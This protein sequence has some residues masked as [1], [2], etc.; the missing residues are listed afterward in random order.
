MAVDTVRCVAENAAV[1]IEVLDKNLVLLGD[2]APKL[3]EKMVGN[4]GWGVDRS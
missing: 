2:D 1:L 4:L 3:A